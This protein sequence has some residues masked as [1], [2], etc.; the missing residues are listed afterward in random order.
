LLL[1]Q[2]VESAPDVIGALDAQGRLIYLNRAGRKWCGLPEHGGDMPDLSCVQLYPPAAAKMI[3]EVA[4]PAA[5]RDGM[6]RGSSVLCD[7]EGREHPVDQIV[8]A[9]RQEDGT[10]SGFSTEFRDLSA[11]R[12]TEQ[13]LRQSEEQFSKAFYASPDPYIIADYTTNRMVDVNDAY[14]R[15]FGVTRE[16]A[17]GKRNSELGLWADLGQ[18]DRFVEIMH[19]DGEVHEME[20]HRRTRTG[21]TVICLV[22]AFRI[23]IGGRPCTFYQLR[24]VTRERQSQQAV[25]ESEQLFSKVFRGSPHPM[26]VV[27]AET[28][29]I[30]EA[31]GRFCEFMGRGR[32]QVVG[33]TIRDIRSWVDYAER[34][35]IYAQILQHGSLHGREVRIFNHAGDIRLGRYSGELLD[36]GGRKCVV[37]VF[38]DLTDL[39]RAEQALTASE[40]KFSKA[41]RA[42]PDAIS[43]S[44][45]AEGRFLELNEGFTRM[46][47]WTREEVLGR[48]S[49]DLGI[50]AEPGDRQRIAALIRAGQPVTNESVVMR[51]KTGE[52][53]QCLFSADK[54]EIGGQT[55]LLAVVRDVTDRQRLEAQLRHAQKMESVGQLAGGVAH[56]FN[57]I[58][59]VIQG[60]ASFLLEDPSLRPTALDSVRQIR[61]SAEFAANLTRQLLLFSRKQVLRP[62]RLALNDVVARMSH[63]LQ[64]V[65]GETIALEF[66]P[67]PGLPEIQAD[68]GMVEQVLLN[69]AVNARDAMPHGGRLAIA[70]L[71]LTADAEYVWRV[72]QARPG[73]MVGLRVRDS[74]VG[75]PAEVIPRIFDP[76][77]TTKK[78]GKGTGLGLATV[79]GIVQQHA[80]WIEVESQPGQGATFTVWFPE[81]GAAAPE[82]APPEPTLSSNLRGTETILVV[83]DK[84]SVRTLLQAVLERFGYHVVTAA[85]G[86]EALGR[87]TEHKDRIGLLF[88][89]VMMPGRL[90]GK[91][92]AERLRADRPT[93]KVVFCSGYDANVLD[94][95]ALQAIGARFLPKPFDVM[96]LAE[97][98]RELLDAK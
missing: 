23:D 8:V 78:E 72:P 18:R 60:H 68:V 31:N 90:T 70:T 52:L 9:F 28:G 49:I 16:E 1:A 21:E 15:R 53:R 47:G 63:L 79:Y 83:E 84:D 55:C 11:Q 71:S 19:R 82:S 62:V 39:K 50:W 48:S 12:L 97:V 93:L 30:I 29:K 43:I 38:E 64:S 25:R 57:N 77:F 3:K 85:D 36:L 42:T 51:H 67:A 73:R 80:G 24:D 98:V 54:I 22:T 34:D 37:S 86:D 32:E 58:L 87:W 45:L 13:A 89:D 5:A 20:Q 6:W 10:V 81:Q 17:I 92:L 4:L 56:D 88:T 7:R 44:T 95:L 61:Q 65:V 69:L 96:R 35:E 2:I 74:G 14:C 66:A 76:F 40:D 26:L 75:I 41:F 46:V 27:A 33:R 94:P 91:D 59:T